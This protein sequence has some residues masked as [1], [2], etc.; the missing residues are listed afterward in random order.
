MVTVRLLCLLLMASSGSAAIPLLNGLVSSHHHHHIQRQLNSD[1]SSS[2]HNPDNTSSSSFPNDEEEV[3]EDLQKKNKT[4]TKALKI[5]NVLGGL[6]LTRLRSSATRNLFSSAIDDVELIREYFSE[7]VGNGGLRDGMSQLDALEASLDWQARNTSTHASTVDAGLGYSDDRRDRRIDRLVS[8]STNGPFIGDKQADA[9]MMDVVSNI[10]PWIVDRKT[11]EHLWTMTHQNGRSQAPGM[12]P[13]VFESLYMAGYVLSWADSIWYYPPL[14]VYGHPFSI[15]DVLGGN[16]DSH[17]IVTGAGFLPDENPHHLSAFYG[18]YPDIGVPGLAIITATTPIYY[19]G[20]LTYYDDT[21]STTTTYWYNDTYIAHAGLDI[22]MDSVSVLLEDLQDT[23]AE[24]SFALLTNTTLSPI[25]ISQSV[26]EKIYP[27]RTGWEESRVTYQ[28]ADG[29]IV[30]DRRNQTYLVSDT[31]HQSLTNVTTTANWTAL[32]N[33]I[34]NVPRGGRGYMVLNLTLANDNDNKPVPYYVMFDRWQYVSD[35]VLLVLVPVEQV[36]K[37]VDVV[38]SQPTVEAQ[39]KAGQD[40]TISLRLT[41]RG[42]LDVQVAP[43]A[44]PEWLE[45]TTNHTLNA[46]QTLGPG[47]EIQITAILKSDGLDVGTSVSTVSFRVVD[48]GYND[49][50]YD[51][52]VSFDATLKVHPLQIN[53]NYI[54]TAAIAGYIFF[55]I[56]AGTALGCM[57]WTIYYWNHRVVRGS[58]PRFLM[59]LGVGTLIM[60]SSIL[61]FGID[62]NNASEEEADKACMASAWLASIGFIICFSAIFSKIWRI[63]KIFRNK[64]IQRITATQQ[65]VLVPFA[66]LFTINFILLLSWTLVDPLRFERVKVDSSSPFSDTHGVCRFENDETIGFAVTIVV[67]NFLAILLACFEAYRARK[68]GDEFSESKWVAVT[69]ATWFQVFVV[70]F[71]VMFLMQGHPTASYFLKSAIVFVACMSLLLFVFVPKVIIQ[72][73]NAAS[74]GSM[75]S[76]QESALP[77][78]DNVVSSGQQSSEF[79]QQSTQDASSSTGFGI[80]V[81]RSPVISS[82]RTE[83]Q[84]ILRERMRALENKILQLEGENAALKHGAMPPVSPR[85]DDQAGYVETHGANCTPETETLSVLGEENRAPEEPLEQSIPEQSDDVGLSAEHAA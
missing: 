1:N 11:N 32:A 59:M 30:D 26:V 72:R 77:N 51:R 7:A 49:C 31:L 54:G 6:D 22:P 8:N 67:V 25:A 60:S 33:E 64:E 18:P 37:A 53:H 29:S 35:W 57:G 21:T 4:K 68:I 23:L 27:A 62:D 28:L 76:F 66:I 3:E 71:P 40:A 85:T 70:G 5:C 80:R 2:S 56:V 19:T 38:F 39:V 61:V 44:C 79:Q 43:S 55:W 58:Q 13:L 69:V 41:N 16:F 9:I 36:D 75:E 17:G 63:N 45:F 65:D 14:S 78:V 74:K 46:R 10:L 83:V 42:T 24:G 50:F 34:A 81:V 20:P 82:A 12:E 48:D 73:S 52:D 47:D 15:A 84:E